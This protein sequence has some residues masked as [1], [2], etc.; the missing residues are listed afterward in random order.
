MNSLNNNCNV[1]IEKKDNSKVTTIAK[2][3][4]F[5]DKDNI[6]LKDGS[7]NSPNYNNINP[8]TKSFLNQ[9]LSKNFKN[10]KE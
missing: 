4:K 1:C 8:K 9:N 10:K 7:S 5:I 2:E 6:N 3:N